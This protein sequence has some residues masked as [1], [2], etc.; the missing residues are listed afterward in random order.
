MTNK[1][2]VI[3]FVWAQG[4][5]LNA[6]PN[7]T[8]VSRETLDAGELIGFFDNGKK[9]NGLDSRWSLAAV[10]GGND[11]NYAIADEGYTIAQAWGTEKQA[12]IEKIRKERRAR[13]VRLTGTK[14]EIKRYEKASQV[15]YGTGIG[16]GVTW[17]VGKHALPQI[18]PV[19]GF[20]YTSALIGLGVWILS[21]VSGKSKDRDLSGG[22]AIKALGGMVGF[23][24]IGLGVVL[25]MLGLGSFGSGFTAILAL[26]GLAFGVLNERR[27]SKA[28]ERAS[29]IQ[30]EINES[31][32]REQK[33]A[34]PKDFEFQ[35]GGKNT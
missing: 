23:G 25:G 3:I 10:A 32:I 11:E 4:A 29:K 30:K 5:L 14:R 28:E 7:E 21:Q 6:K 8:N 22:G 24:F 31:K 35:F 17:I 13:E 9:L 18:F 19:L 1:M 26:S 33:L 34:N 15:L 16:A 12:E 27:Q 2:L 20:L